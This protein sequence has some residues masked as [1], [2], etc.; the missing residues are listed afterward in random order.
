MDDLDTIFEALLTK[1][2]VQWGVEKVVE[3]DAILD[4]LLA[5]EFIVSDLEKV[6]FPA[7]IEGVNIADL[8]STFAGS[9]RPN[10]YFKIIDSFES[11]KGHYFYAIPYSPD[12]LPSHFFSASGESHD[13]IE[14][15]EFDTRK[16]QF[17][18]TEFHFQQ[19][20]GLTLRYGGHFNEVKHDYLFLI[21]MLDF[22]TLDRDH[23]PFFHQLQFLGTTDGDYYFT[24]IK[25][26]SDIDYI[27]AFLNA[28]KSLKKDA[29]MERAHEYAILLKRVL[30]LPPFI[31]HHVQ[32]E[33]DAIFD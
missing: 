1:T 15:V 29:A 33:L 9:L 32:R 7:L 27:L 25:L 3:V 21:G 17:L 18:E 5:C 24:P 14:A 16:F 19:I 31:E 20:P 10:P 4:K 30:T 22:N 2:F 13:K 11:K 8:V 28:I 12:Y 23:D 26:V 6:E